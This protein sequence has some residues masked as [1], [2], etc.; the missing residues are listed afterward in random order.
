MKPAM[1]HTPV[2]TIGLKYPLPASFPSV[3]F[4]SDTSAREDGFAF[5]GLLVPAEGFF[6]EESGAADT[7]T[8]E[9]ASSRVEGF[10]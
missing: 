1:N 6:E 7:L 9:D 3:C 2:A 5:C 10:R 4:G 8:S